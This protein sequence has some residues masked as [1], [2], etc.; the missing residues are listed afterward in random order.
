MPLKLLFKYP[1]RGRS[2]RFFDGLDSI[3][4]LLYDKENYHISCT[5]DDDDMEMRNPEVINR[6][7]SYPNV[8]IAWGI[9]G[10]KVDAINRDLPDYGDIIVVMSDDMRFTLFGFDEIIRHAFEGSDLDMLAHFPDQDAKDALA[11]MYISG[12]KFYERFNYIYN[13]V[14]Y[15]LFCDNE[16]QDIAKQ[17]GKYKYFDTQMLVHLNGAY[18]HLERDALFDAQQKIGFT[19]DQETYI[20]RRATNF[21]L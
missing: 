19:V 15:S 20:K 8:S 9:S 1:S 11:T 2:K 17:L 16:I 10:S 21:N 4:P 3:V 5:L 14:Y 13:P 12:R 18:G 7:N 6:I